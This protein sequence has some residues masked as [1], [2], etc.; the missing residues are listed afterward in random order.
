VTP[1]R[2]NL[3]QRWRTSEFD[4]TIRTNSGGY[5]EDFEFRFAD[6]EFAFMGDSFTFGH[7]VEVGERYTNLFSNRLK[8]RI[9]PL[10]VVSLGRNDGFQ[11]EHYEY[12]LRKHPELRPKAIVVGLYLGNDLEPDVK[13][14]RF[15]R[16][17]LTL[18]LPYRTIENGQLIS[19]AP[20]RIPGFRTLVGISRTARLFA[21][22]L[23]QTAYR[24]YL[25]AGDAV[26]PNDYNSDA[27]EFGRLNDFSRRTFDSLMNIADLA[28]E[29]GGRLVVML[30]PQNFYAGAVRVPHLAPALWPRIPEILANGGLPKAVVERCN[31]LGLDCIDAGTV[32]SSEDFFPGDAHWNREGHRKAADLLYEHFQTGGIE[33]Y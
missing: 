3:N 22:T 11:P 32:M 25:F 27:L 31:Q 33:R 18:E 1:L 20:Y 10:H 14:T 28:R 9:D 7:G 16:P 21:I 2:G 26:L 17:N 23:N 13:E 29:R 19:T 4:V 8:D 15:D 24:K 12:F 5:R 30:I 6:V